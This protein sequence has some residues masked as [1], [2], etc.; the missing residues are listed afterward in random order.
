M[1]TERK[2]VEIFVGL[3]VLIGFSVIA[4][5][6]VVFGRLGQSFQD[7]YPVTVIF[8]NAS[9]LVKG[10]DV[11]LAG[12]P[13]GTVADAPKL[14]GSSYAVQVR[15]L[16]RGDV[17]IPKMS[18]LLVGS[19]GLM[20][21]RY[22]DVIPQA[23]F[24]PND[25][26][27]PNDIIQGT[28]ASGLDDLTASGDQ[29][30]KQLSAAVFEIQKMAVNLNE[31]LFEDKNLNNLQETLANLKTTSA[32]WSESSKQLGPI[33]ASAQTAVDS[34]KGTMKTTDAAAAD[35]RLAIADVRKAAA[36]IDKTVASAKG[37]ID[38]GKILV[39]KASDGGGPLGTLISDK[40]AS[41]NLKSFLFNLKRSGPLF[42][43][44]R[45]VPSTAP[46]R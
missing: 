10:S 7:N 1:S 36:S 33:L 4:V 14:A 41:E 46:A 6:V 28:R 44:D 19:S 16:I 39:K 2:N 32:T 42:Y 37:L 30:M 21:D 26:A 11:L 22:V 35:L 24:D 20:G 18:T 9:G 15:L 43:K 23:N 3:F 34:A 12:A 31:K 25:V 13:I 5:L 38:S 29:V 40:A 27:K 17:K 45:P 8:P